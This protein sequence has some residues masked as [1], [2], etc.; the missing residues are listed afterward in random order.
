MRIAYTGNFRVAFTTESHIAAS[1]T[2][3]G[4]T[5]I[6]L[7][8]DQMP[9]T[10]HGAEAIRQRADMWMFTRTW[11]EDWPDGLRALDMLRAAGVPTVS[12]HLDLY[13]GLARDYQV[14]LENP[15]WA[16]D[17]V[18]TADGDPDHQ[19]EFER[20]GIAHQFMPPG[21]YGAECRPGNVRRNYATDVAF[22]GSWRNYHAEWSYRQEL[23]EWLRST[24]G[25]RFATW[26]RGSAIRGRP[27]NDLYAS[28]K[29]VVGDSCN[30]GFALRRYVSDRLFEAPG[31]GAF[32]IFPRIEGVQEWLSDREH[33]V[34]YDYGD[35]DQLRSLIDYYVGRGVER[36]RIRR[37]GQAHVREHHTYTHRM[38]NMLAQVGAKDAAH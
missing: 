9:L 35:F 2:E 15:F 13:L 30:P 31:R 17:H 19:A 5:V 36:E 16:T 24:Y 8:E 14:T 28:V 12:Y 25:R 7:Q 21:V 3:L 20:R 29:V 33:V 4:H 26:P 32:L 22:V 6:R 10:Q 1:L 34:L 38:R 27:L 23:V 11:H 37:A 18:F